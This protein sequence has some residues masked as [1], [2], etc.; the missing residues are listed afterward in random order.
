MSKSYQLHR[1]PGG[2][3]PQK[4]SR[5]LGPSTHRFFSGAFAVSFREGMGPRSFFIE[6]GPHKPLLPRLLYFGYPVSCF[7]DALKKTSN[8]QVFFW[9][10]FLFGDGVGLPGFETRSVGG[11]LKNCTFSRQA[12]EL[13]AEKD[14]PEVWCLKRGV[15]SYLP[16][17]WCWD[18]SAEKTSIRKRL[19][20]EEFVVE[21][22]LR[23]VVLSSN[24]ICNDDINVG[25][26]VLGSH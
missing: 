1:W 10:I 4:E 16:V 8:L 11:S 19:F 26:Q 7:F 5:D 20:K 23:I 3:G 22:H 12:A 13:L 17:V 2:A 21:S 9:V 18:C 15:F 6:M 24:F 25:V 14:D